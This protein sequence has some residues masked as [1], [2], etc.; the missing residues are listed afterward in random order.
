MTGWRYSQDAGGTP[1][2]SGGWWVAVAALLLVVE[3][4]LPTGRARAATTI[5]N[6]ATLGYDLADGRHTLLSNST[7]TDVTSGHS[8]K[9]VVKDENGVP[10]RSARVDAKSKNATRADAVTA[11]AVTD[12][13]GAYA[14]AGLAA[15]TYDVYITADGRV[16]EVLPGIT[17]GPDTP[18]VALE[19]RA[20]AAESWPRGLYMAA[21]PFSF[22]TADLGAALGRV[23][24]LKAARW[25]PDKAGGHYV[26]YGQDA[27][28][29]ATAPGLG[30]WIQV[31]PGEVLGVAQPGTPL[32]ES[33]PYAVPLTAGW[34]MVGNPFCTDL[35]WAGVEVRANGQTVSL[36]TAA[37]NNWVRPYAWTY[38]P[39][40]GE[41]VLVDAAYP[42]ARRTLPVW[43]ACWVRAL[44]DCDLL[45]APT[46]AAAK[47]ATAATRSAQS[48]PAWSLQLVTR[49]GE[50]RDGF[51]YMGVYANAASC[52]GRG[53][54]QTPPR[55]SPYVDL[56]FGDGR[57]A[58]ADLATDFRPPAAGRAEWDFVVRSDLAD[59]RVEITWPDLSEVPDRYCVTLVDVDAKRRQYMRTT[60]SYVFNTGAG[61]GER[62]FKIEVDPTPWARL[63]V[64]NLQ[65]VMGRAAGATVAYDV[66][67]P[68][69]VD[70][71]V[72]TLAGQSV[73][74]LAR[75]ARAAAGTNMITWD[76]TDSSGRMMANGPY[77]CAISAVTEEGQAVKGMRTIILKR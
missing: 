62:H 10:V 52:D 29:P 28:F 7:A 64:G 61:G 37:Q 68:A 39:A 33:R 4:S 74:V 53:K 42:G 63:Q 72:R 76:G 23:S 54:L 5:V 18:A 3:V 24:G 75:G 55:L 16:P 60:G 48:A 2:P 25:V 36:E 6:T 27:T 22:A 73:K 15:G 20:P 69:A 41:Y 47:S 11:T 40:A 9:G 21:L 66:S 46:G 58:A 12:V 65:Q 14:L 49:V 45:M 44:V 56:S 50:L 17:V 71:E 13:A 31:G 35:E 77:L 67:S 57:A 70:I 38:D 8:I 43:Q 34:N 59:A 30:Y 26:Y 32:D 19:T 1:R 51:N